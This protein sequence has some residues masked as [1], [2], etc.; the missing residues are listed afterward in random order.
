MERLMSHV[1]HKRKQTLAE[2]YPPSPPCSCDVCKSYCKRPGWWTVEEAA[3]AI[4]A[5]YGKRMMLEMA[6][7]F[8]L[9]V[10]SPAFKGCEVMFAY[11]EYASRGCT[12]LLDNKC[13]LHETGYQPLE[14]RYCHHERI[15]MGPRC[16]AD[17]EKDWNTPAGRSLIVQ[18]SQLVGFA[19]H[20][21]IKA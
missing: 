13:E 6:P 11:N 21:T 5:G 3:R 12:F 4:E 17:I 2:K 16:H 14:C 10:L 1:K 20:R 19:K 7:G 9:G 8:S 18:W 15:G